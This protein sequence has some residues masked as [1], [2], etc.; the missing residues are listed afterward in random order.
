MK[1][2]VGDMVKMNRGYSTPGLVVEISNTGSLKWV[3]ILWSDYDRPSVE[4]YSDVEIFDE[5]R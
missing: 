1:V 4:R 5:S 2:K 3:R